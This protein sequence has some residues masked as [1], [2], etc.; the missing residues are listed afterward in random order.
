MPRWHCHQTLKP[1]AFDP[2]AGGIK[3]DASNCDGRSFGA[4]VEIDPATRPPPP[5]DGEAIP[6]DFSASWT[7]SVGIARVSYSISVEGGAETA[8]FSDDLSEGTIKPLRTSMDR[9]PSAGRGK[10]GNGVD[11]LPPTSRGGPFA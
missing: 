5:G 4:T 9:R 8:V 6:A 10:A 11:R 7:K 3:V 2:G 1:P